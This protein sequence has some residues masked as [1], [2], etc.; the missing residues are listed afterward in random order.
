MFNSSVLEVVVGLFL[1]FFVFAT[2]CSG[3][4]EWISRALRLRAEYLLRGLR[5]MLDGAGTEQRKELSTTASSESRDPRGSEGP[6]T[7]SQPAATS[8]LPSPEPDQAEDTGLADRLLRVPLVATFGQQVDGDPTDKRF[9]PS[10]L[11]AETFAAAI[12]DMIVPD[13]RGTTS[14]D[15]VIDGITA[16]PEPARSTFLALAKTSRGSTTAFRTSVA[17]WYDDNMTRVSGWYKRHVTLILIGLALVVTITCN[18]NTI[19]LA[20]SLYTNQDAREALVNQASAVTSCPAGQTTECTRQATEAVNKLGQT[21]LPMFWQTTNPSCAAATAHCST[22]ER[23]G[24]DSV[25]GWVIAIVGWLI[26]IGA[27][28]MGAPFWF[29]LL[30]KVASL[31]STGDPPPKASAQP[32]VPEP[33]EVGQVAVLERPADT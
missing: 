19:T 6:P 28:S 27:I 33:T 20:R 3:I 14:M 8:A 13:E 16:L 1:V 30:N 2:I 17:R 25:S 12:I 18:I 11:P 15:T 31:R 5:T 32:S 9:M 22:L 23:V 4:V 29:N 26:T 21:S 7:G 10:Y 24:L